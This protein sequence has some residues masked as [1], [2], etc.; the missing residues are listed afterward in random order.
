MKS[1]RIPRR[2]F[3]RQSALAGAGLSLLSLS[4][5]RCMLGSDHPYLDT[6]G[7]QVY[8]V[9]DQLEQDPNGT[10]KAIAD[11]GYQQVEL[12]D[13]RQLAT[14]KPIANDLGMEVNS[15]F[16]LWTSLTGNWHLVPDEKDQQYNFDR[17]LEDASKAGINHLVFGYLNKGER[18]TLDQYK[19]HCDKLNE[20]GA[21]AKA[22]GIQLCYH[23]HSFEFEPIEGKVPFELLIERLDPSAVQF[24]LDVFWA[25][26]GGYDPVQLLERIGDRTRLLHLKDL[27]AGTPTIYDEGAVPKDAFKELG[28]GNI[29]LKEVIAMAQK[30][31]IKYCFVEQDQS[32]DPINSIGES[33]HY[34]QLG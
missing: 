5:I 29:N 6:I 31:D 22:A 34:M 15:S 1:H 4:N 21:K 16:M 3:M 28:N 13:T 2:Q 26:L 30:V 23:N 33:I 27:Q 9:R 8:T 12:M 18:D 25:A 14:L 10:L 19:S 17:V 32:P 24:E 20:A 11:F 7:L